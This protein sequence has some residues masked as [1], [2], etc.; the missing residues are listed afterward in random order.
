MLAVN[1]KESLLVSPF[2]GEKAFISL[3]GK[4]GLREILNA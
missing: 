3:F 4:E 1:Q 2:Q